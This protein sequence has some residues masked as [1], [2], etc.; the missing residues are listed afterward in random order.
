MVKELEIGK[1]YLI[2]IVK[3][4]E[5]NRN[6][7]KKNVGTNKGKYLVVSKNNYEY[8]VKFCGVPAENVEV[9][10]SISVADLICGYVCAF[11]TDEEGVGS[12]EIPHQ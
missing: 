9:L 10:T 8:T 2:F 3:I 12:A 1:S 7:Y 4:A 5:G 6:R 11:P